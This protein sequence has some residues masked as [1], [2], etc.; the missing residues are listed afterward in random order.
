MKRALAALAA[1]AVLGLAGTAQAAETL[2]VVIMASQ[3]PK[4]EAPKYAA[5]AEYLKASSPQVDDIKLRVAKDYS[6]AAQLF[7]AG[8]VFARSLLASGERPES[9][10]TPVLAPSHGAALNAV[11][12]GAADSAVAKNTIFRPADYPGLAVVGGDE[13]ENPDN[14]LIMTKA[15]HAKHGAAV[16]GALTGREAAGGPLAAA[17]KEAFNARGFIA[18]TDR[19]FVHTYRLIEKARI[20]PQAFDFAF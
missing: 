18:T 6:E 10:Y 7:K 5:L 11:Q 15:T 2:R 3:D 14:T 4:K 1:V 20:D 9:V 17:V 13:E 12:S 19:D 8:E 16:A